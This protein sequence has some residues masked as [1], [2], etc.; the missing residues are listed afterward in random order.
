VERLRYFVPYVQHADDP[1]AEDAFREFGLANFE[2]VAQVANRFSSPQ[3]RAWLASDAVPQTRKGFLGLLLGLAA[4]D[5]DRRANL[6]FL[7]EQILLPGDDFRAGFDGQ[8]AGYLLLSGESGLQLIEESYLA[9]PQAAV[10]DVR[11]ALAALRFYQQYGK[12]IDTPRLAAAVSK[13]LPRPEFAESAITDLARWQAWQY[14]DPIA[15]LYGQGDHNR[16]EIKRA[17]VGYLLACPTDAAKQA[18]R[19]LRAADPTGIATAEDVLRKLNLP[20]Q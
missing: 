9:K 17:I 2:A 5:A 15:A 3:V 20:R 13:V 18:L 10:G 16:P 6:A 14:V 19:K 1:I 12:Q 4:D 8:L 11:H 7:Q